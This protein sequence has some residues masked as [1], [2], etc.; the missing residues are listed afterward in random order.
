MPA[1]T[2]EPHRFKVIMIHMARLGVKIPS[3]FLFRNNLT[4]ASLYLL[5]QTDKK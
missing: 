1:C 4:F 2:S 3:F 5:I